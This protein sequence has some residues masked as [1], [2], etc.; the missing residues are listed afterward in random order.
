[1]G[2]GDAQED[3]NIREE[4]K[5]S[6][7]MTQRLN[8]LFE[9]ARALKQEY[10]HLLKTGR[11]LR[12]VIAAKE[13]KNA[14]EIAQE[15][16]IHSNIGQESVSDV[17]ARAK[18]IVDAEKQESQL[19]KEEASFLQDMLNELAATYHH[20]ES[21]IRADKELYDLIKEVYQ[22]TLEDYQL[23]VADTNKV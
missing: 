1:M 10:R 2:E 21:I 22:K 16:F 13:K 3:V 11:K 8:G 5:L 19:S 20:G 6:D 9:E 12:K 7:V 18:R 4:E 23:E 15:K 17:A 14:G